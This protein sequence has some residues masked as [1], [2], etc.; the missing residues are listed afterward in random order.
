MLMLMHALAYLPVIG[1]VYHALALPLA[2]TPFVRRRLLKTPTHEVAAAIVTTLHT[3]YI[4]QLGIGCMLQRTTP[5]HD[6]AIARHSGHV[7][8]SYFVFDTCYLVWRDGALVL[9]NKYL[10]HHIV[11]I[12]LCVMVYCRSFDACLP[13]LLAWYTLLE[14]SNVLL[15]AWEFSRHNSQ[16]VHW[17]L[18][19]PFMLTYFLGRGS[20]VTFA[21]HN[22]WACMLG[23]GTRIGTNDAMGMGLVVSIN[24]MSVWF[25]YRLL[26][27]VVFKP[28]MRCI[29]L[30]V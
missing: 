12:A 23:D 7:S 25:M 27:V 9:K 3:W 24:A 21:T 10:A 14:A 26:M 8:L 29:S 19:P 16:R 22:L 15:K 1:C 17:M 5:A 6:D 2:Q 13:S 30:G 28:W 20:A 18:T 4:A 11:A